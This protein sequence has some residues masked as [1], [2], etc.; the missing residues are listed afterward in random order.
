MQVFNR[1]VLELENVVNL[2][3]SLE[4]LD[5]AKGDERSQTL[6]VRWALWSEVR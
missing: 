3:L 5:D 4:T 2:A 1:I 6:T